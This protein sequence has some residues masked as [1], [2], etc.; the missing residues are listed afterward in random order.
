M[1]LIISITNKGPH[2]AEVISERISEDGRERFPNGVD[3]VEVGETQEFV[4]HARQSLRVVEKPVAEPQPQPAGEVA[5]INT[6]QA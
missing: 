6:Q 3:L 4:V 1:S 2:Q 5:T